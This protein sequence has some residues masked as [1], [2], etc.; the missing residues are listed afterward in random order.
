MAL[1]LAGYDG[2]SVAEASSLVIADAEGHVQRVLAVRKL[3]QVFV[4]F[5][6][7]IKPA[8]SR[9]AW[10]PDGRTIAVAGLTMSKPTAY[11][12][13]VL[14]D[15]ST[16][17]QRR[18]AT[19]AQEA[20]ISPAIVDLGWLDST[21]LVL[22]HLADGHPPY[23]IST[24]DLRDGRFSPV[25]GDVA[26]YGGISITTDRQ[27][28]VSTRTQGRAGIWIG[29]ASGRDMSPVVP[30]SSAQPGWAS[31][32]QQ[33]DLV[34]SAD[35]TDGP[36][37]WV[38]R[39]GARAATLIARGSRPT[40]TSN[41]RAVLFLGSGNHP[42]LIRAAL[43][44]SDPV[45]LVNGPFANF[46]L[47]PDDTTVMFVDNRTTLQSIWAVPVAGGAPH[48]VVPRN[49]NNPS[50]SHD[51][52]RLLFIS[53][54][55]AN[56]RDPV[57]VVCDLPACDRPLES[58]LP[59]QARRGTVRWTPDDGGVAFACLANGLSENIW[60][61]PLNGGAI[62]QLTQ[63][64]DGRTI[65]SFDWSPDGRRLTVARASNLSDIVLLRRPR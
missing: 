22:N 50:V 48:Q 19:I 35:T 58:P 20:A 39:A 46:A 52:R 6:Y 43:D 11:A 61:Q 63:F 64:A 29:D 45:Q 49:A 30:E 54:A 42:G 40:V 60:V 25:T 47:T 7:P 55:S 23:R 59:P 12:E 18:V 31:L 62:W 37:V 57:V 15:V 44:G 14:I 10:S 26:S 51:G 24:F 13:V 41:G 8:M 16:G 33:G 27:A 5:G 34:F 53:R 2:R 3:P 65:S 1:L 28:M 17:A 36:A 38:L 4:G 56:N 9:L 21:R 32:D